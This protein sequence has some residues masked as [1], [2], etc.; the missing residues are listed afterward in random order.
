MLCS[1]GVLIIEAIA[2][3]VVMLRAGQS[4]QLPLYDLIIFKV[5]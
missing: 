2:Q 1:K 3:K 5:L 4:S